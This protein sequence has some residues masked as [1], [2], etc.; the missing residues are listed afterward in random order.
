MT[1]K[2]PLTLGTG[3]ALTAIA[4]G[5]LTVATAAPPVKTFNPLR[6][7][8]V[9]LGDDKVEVT[10]TNTSRKNVRLPKWQLPSL[11]AGDYRNPSRAVLPPDRPDPTC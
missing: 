9:S 2:L 1:R 7:S 8:V 4:A 10:L 5:A 6:V 3:L 11:R